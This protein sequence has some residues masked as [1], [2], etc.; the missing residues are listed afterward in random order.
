MFEYVPAEGKEDN[1]KLLHLHIHTLLVNYKRLRT[2][3]IYEYDMRTAQDRTNWL[4]SH[5][6]ESTDDDDD[7]DHDE[8][9]DSC[10]FKFIRISSHK[11]TP[12]PFYLVF[13]HYKECNLRECVLHLCLR[14][15]NVS[16]YRF[17]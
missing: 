13:Y 3:N 12:L 9:D 14:L 7:E 10:Q 2:D 8:D 15:L 4:Q 1:Q 5:V 17:T 11:W 16:L 6:P